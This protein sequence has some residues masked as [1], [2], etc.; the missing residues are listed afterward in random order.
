VAIGATISSQAQDATPNAA[1]LLADLGLPEITLTA[2]IEGLTLSQSEV[3]AGRYLVT[4]DNQSRN[5]DLLVEIVRLV[6]DDTAWYAATAIA[7][8]VAEG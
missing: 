3:P 5:P 1:S 2:T 8:P 4:L 6:R 7:L